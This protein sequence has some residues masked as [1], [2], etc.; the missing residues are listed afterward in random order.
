MAEPLALQRIHPGAVGMPLYRAVKR[1]LLREIESGSAAPGKTLPN[2]AQLAQGFGVSI[3]TVRRAVDELVADHILVR[4]QGRGT[5]VATHDSARFL[6]QF[7]HVERSDGLRESP[8]VELVSFQRIRSEEADAEPL[9]LRA[10]DPVLQMENRLMLQGRAVVHDRL[11]VPV[12]LV[13]GLTEKKL[14]ERPGTIYQLYQSAFGITVVRAIERARAVACDRSVARVLGLSVG[15]PVLQ[16]RRVALT[17]G[18]KPVELRISTIDTS[19]HDY[20]QTLS[21]PA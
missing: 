16:V 3:G 15:E 11:V 5:F 9:G 17:F 14:A 18:D 6:F 7:F 21:Q 8:Q 19:Q 20:V 4:R 13:R 2:E 12:L 1:A 10:G